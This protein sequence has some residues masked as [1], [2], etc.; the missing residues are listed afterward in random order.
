MLLAVSFVRATVRGAEKLDP[1]AS[2]VVVSNHSSY[3][4]I[5]ALYSALPLE[6]RFFAKKGLFSIPLL[7]WHLG[8]AGHIPVV[9]GDPRASLKS[10]SEGAK[11]I[12]ARGIS[13]LVF[14]E[15]GRT[16]TG[17]RP[18]K[19]GAAYIAIKAGVPVVPVG[20]VNMRTVL[21]MHSVFLRP[22]RHRNQH[23]RPH[24]YFGHDLARQRASERNPAGARR[25][26]GRRPR[27][28]RRSSSKVTN[29]MN[30]QTIPDL[31]RDA[32]A[33]H[34]HALAL[35]QPAGKDVHTWTWSQYLEAA[36]EIAAGLHSLGL[37]QR[38]SYRALCGNARRV[39]SGRSGNS[40]SGRWRERTR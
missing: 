1:H 32:A 25:R 3:M 21:P 4:D 24:R 36:E 20:L 23:R 6:I 5:P 27:C 17:M 33:K 8:H 10:M 18:F 29:C 30:N 11:L 35:R 37:A 28:C 12:R 16:E 19:E 14:P 9:R 7:G 15:G 22:G 34:G 39:L 26:T 31:L 2:Y 40:H 38:R 13:V